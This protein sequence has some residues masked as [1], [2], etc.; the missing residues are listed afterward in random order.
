MSGWVDFAEQQRWISGKR[1]GPTFQ[2]DGA[3]T[4]GLRGP[5]AI[6][7]CASRVDITLSDGRR[8]LVEGPSALPAVLGLVKGLMA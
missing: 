4:L 2:P 3:P 6:N 1:A 8:V 5:V 7:Y